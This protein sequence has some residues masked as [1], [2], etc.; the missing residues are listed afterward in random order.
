MRYVSN[1]EDW[2]GSKTK[3]FSDLDQAF[4]SWMDPTQKKRKGIGPGHI[5]HMFIKGC[6][7]LCPGLAVGADR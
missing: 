3:G 6:S 7:A 1:L 2:L 5:A 4:V